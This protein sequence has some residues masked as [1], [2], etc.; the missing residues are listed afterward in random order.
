MVVDLP[1]PF[2][3]EE[4]KIRRAE[5]AEINMVNR[6]ELAG[7]AWSDLFASMANLFLVSVIRG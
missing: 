2:G 6:D 1:Q 4:A 3:T 7:S 5:C